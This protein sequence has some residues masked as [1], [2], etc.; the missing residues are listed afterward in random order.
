MSV[1]C[2]KVSFKDLFFTYLY[3]KKNFFPP[4]QSQNVSIGFVRLMCSKKT[5]LLPKMLIF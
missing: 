4:T 2:I 1:F 3:K 5:F